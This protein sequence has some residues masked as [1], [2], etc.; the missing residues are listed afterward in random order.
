MAAR[1]LL[2]DPDDR[3]R[4]VILQ[5]R[6]GGCY[7]GAEWF[8]IQCAQAT[9]HFVPRLQI[10]TQEI[11]VVGPHS[12]D[13]STRE[14]WFDPPP[15][16]AVG[17]SPDEALAALLDTAP[18][19]PVATSGRKARSADEYLTLDRPQI[20]S[21]DADWLAHCGELHRHWRLALV[22]DRYA[23]EWSGGAWLAVS[24]SDEPHVFDSRLHVVT[25]HNGAPGPSGDESA[26]QAFWRDPPEWIA[27]GATPNAAVLALL[28]KRAPR[29]KEV[30]RVEDAMRDYF[31][32][33]EIFIFSDR[34][35]GT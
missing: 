17:G 25:G 3:W 5:D 7:S 14:F 27:A 10:V 12:D 1:D 16:I 9:D 20:S 8:A 4:I 34:Y 32:R 13:C 21:G 15:W 29:S 22:Q 31:G 18:P 26:A 6:Y 2:H 28:E 24:R 35:R 11:E 19:E 33:G 30:V 23:G